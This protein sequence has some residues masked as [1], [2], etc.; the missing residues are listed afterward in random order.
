MRNQANATAHSAVIRSKPIRVASSHI[1]NRNTGSTTSLTGKRSSSSSIKI[2]DPK[3]VAVER[4]LAQKK[5]SMCVTSTKS[6]KDPRLA[7][8]E[9]ILASK[10]MPFTKVPF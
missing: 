4:I 3:L 2:K 1:K 7:A 10:K 6:S 8:V 5:N 9:K